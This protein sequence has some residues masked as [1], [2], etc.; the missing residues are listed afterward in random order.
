MK[1]TRK[2]RDYVIWG[3]VAF[4]VN[5]GV[6]KALLLWGL[7]YKIANLLAL[8]FNRMFTYITNKL[9][10]FKTKCKDLFSLIKEMTSFFAARML[11]L[12]LDYFGVCLLVEVLRLDALFS[13]VI[14][15]AVVIITNYLLSEL[16][17]FK[18][19]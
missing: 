7:D 11:T 15:S 4:F 8:L 10:V 19:Y 6:F 2:I 18:K 1:N 14:V 12:I 13:K 5:I 17:V 16:V 9:F 3:A